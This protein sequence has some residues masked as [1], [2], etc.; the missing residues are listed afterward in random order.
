MVFEFS[1]I[2]SPRSEFPHRSFPSISE[3]FYSQI[4]KYARQ[5]LAEGVRHAEDLVITPHS[6]LYRVLI[7][8]YNRSNQIEVPASFSQAVQ[9]TL[10]EFF[11]AIQQQKDLEASWK[12]SIY[13]VIQRLDDDLPE[14][15]KHDHWMHG[16]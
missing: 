5:Y 10:R 8:H 11:L 14:F 9:V 15:F 12:K 6:D 1:V 4:E 16:I 2:S 13:K 3:F 7:L